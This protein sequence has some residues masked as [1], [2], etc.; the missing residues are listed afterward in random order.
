MVA[1]FACGFSRVPLSVQKD[2]ELGAIR[3]DHRIY[4]GEVQAFGFW[5]HKATNAAVAKGISAWKAKWPK[6]T[7]HHTPQ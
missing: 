3:G 5:G 4:F 1:C 7:G 2:S 6:T